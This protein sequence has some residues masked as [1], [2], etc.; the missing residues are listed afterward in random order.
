MAMA[1]AAAPSAPAISGG[2][3]IER[4]IREIR[5]RHP[6]VGLAVGVVR[7][8]AFAFQGGGLADIARRAPVTEETPF[9]IA[10]VTKLFTAIAVM[11]LCEAGLVDLDAPATTYLRAYPLVGNPRWRPVTVPNSRPRSPRVFPMILSI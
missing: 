8:G 4:A 9:R 6:S 3:E 10:S 5:G 11:Q 7:A 1:V 2:D